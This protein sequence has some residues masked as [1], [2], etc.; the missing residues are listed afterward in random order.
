MEDGLEARTRLRVARREE[1]DVVAGVDETVGEESDHP[2]GPAVRLRWHREPH[3]TDKPY[4]H[5]ARS[6]SAIADSDRS[7]IPE[8]GR[9]AAAM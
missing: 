2:L 6:K 3:G 5:R 7:R 4:A 1:R 9:F 8:G